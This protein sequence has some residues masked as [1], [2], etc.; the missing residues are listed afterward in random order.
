MYVLLVEYVVVCEALMTYVQVQPAP[1][2]QI[3]STRARVLNG[4]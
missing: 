2:R 3:V 1:A 4:H